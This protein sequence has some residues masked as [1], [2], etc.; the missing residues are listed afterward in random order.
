MASTK[1]IVE[2]ISEDS[3]SSSSNTGDIYRPAAMDEQLHVKKKAYV[4]LEH[5]DL[6]WPAQSVAVRGSK[7]YLGTNPT[8]KAAS[9]ELLEI[10]LENA[11][12]ESLKHREK[13]ITQ[14]IN[15]IRSNSHGLYAVSDDGLFLYD[16]NMKKQISAKGDFSYGLFVTD[17]QIFVGTRAGEV[18][19]YGPGLVPQQTLK[20]HS[21]SIETIVVKDGL[22]FTGSTDRTLR[23]TK[24]TGEPV[25]TIENDSD[26][27]CLDVN[28]DN[29]LVFGDDAAKIHLVNLNDFSEEVIEWHHS[30][31]SLVKWKDAD[32]FASGSDEQ[33]CFWDTS[34]EEE[35][36]H[37]RYL[38]FVHQGQRF[39]KDIAFIGENTVISTSQDGLCVFTPI[40]FIEGV[41]EADEG[42]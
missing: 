11:N 27:N 17:S 35:W 39:Y 6:E 26:V 15:R 22:I 18:C 2:E 32:I 3:Q 40:S 5:I 8:E 41:E 13:K 4:L 1:D 34:F 23:I 28:C 42:E 24:T 10:D 16:W 19:I 33:I 29:M 31:I 14:F 25:K 12:F 38:L 36:E 7:M 30:P 20:I 21:E 37:H 9:S